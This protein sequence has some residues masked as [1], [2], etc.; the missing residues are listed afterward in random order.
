MLDPTQNLNV[1]NR[2]Y[3]TPMENCVHGDTCIVMTQF[4]S[5]FVGEREKH[6]NLTSFITHNS[7][8]EL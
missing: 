5:T 8:F 2:V 7:S 4:S 3:N 6:P 1:S